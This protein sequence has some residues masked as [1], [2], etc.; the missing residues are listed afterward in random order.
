M[1][2]ASGT[3]TT[4][5]IHIDPE[6]RRIAAALSRSAFAMAQPQGLCP[7]CQSDWLAWVF[8]KR[9]QVECHYFGCGW[10]G[11]ESE[12]LA[13]P[14]EPVGEDDEDDEAYPPVGRVCIDEDDE[15]DEDGT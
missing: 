10:S 9:G 13:Y 2:D 4:R 7:R 1:S 15:D 6:F 12:L 5:L 8:G 11:E 14:G 3:A